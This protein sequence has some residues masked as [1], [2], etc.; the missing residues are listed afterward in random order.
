[1]CEDIG[2]A[3]IDLTKQ[4]DEFENRKKIPRNRNHPDIFAK[5]LFFVKLTFLW[6]GIFT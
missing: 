3:E 2:I 5:L 1:M 6:N 4:K